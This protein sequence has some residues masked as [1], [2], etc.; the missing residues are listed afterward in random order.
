MDTIYVVV[1]NKEDLST[2]MYLHKGLPI[3]YL[4]LLGA[5]LGTALDAFHVYSGVERYPVPTFLG[6]AWWVPL[7]FGAA[8]V[9]IGCSHVGADMLLRQRRRPVRLVW[10]LGEGM[11]V[12]LAYVVSAS[13]LDSW[14]KMGLLGVI[15]INF[16]VI[17]GRSWQNLVLSVVTAIT[18][19]LVE[20]VLVATGAFSYVHPDMLEVPYWLPCIYLCASL[21]VGDVGRALFLYQQREVMNEAT[22]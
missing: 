21:A 13:E 18:G 22:H 16:W 1:Y 14:A 4:F 9:A 6:V 2:T 11:W 20:M 19:M 17:A 5:T 3:L 12:V 10:S 7:L 15:Y 8:A